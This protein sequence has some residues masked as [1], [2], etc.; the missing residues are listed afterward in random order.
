MLIVIDRKVEEKQ[1]DKGCLR[2]YAA[3]M[4]FVEQKNDTRKQVLVTSDFDWNYFR[5]YISH[6][7]METKLLKERKII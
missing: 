7:I 3:V 6:C 1:N 2:A 4:F 5:Y